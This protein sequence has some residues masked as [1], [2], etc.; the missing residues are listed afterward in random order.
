MSIFNT[1]RPGGTD[2]PVGSVTM[3]GGATAPSAD[4]LLCDGS[5]VSRT[6]YASLFA[7]LSTTYGIGDGTTTFNVPNTN[8]V[9]VRGAGSQTIN[10]IGYTG[11]RGT[12]Q[13]DQIQGHF[14]TIT[15]TYNLVAQGSDSGAN[16]GR[17]NSGTV[18][19]SPQL[20]T[21][22]TTDGSNGTPRLGPETRPANITLSY[23]IKAV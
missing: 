23:I 20:V 8:G 18:V 14:H 10:A 11:T 7:V 13:S 9:F 19:V 12:A 21:T 2:L 15:N 6:T 5:A 22:A 4:W 3:Y 1:F 17:S 16:A